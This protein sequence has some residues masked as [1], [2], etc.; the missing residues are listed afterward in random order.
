MRF[1]FALVPVFFI[2]FSAACAAAEIE[3][4]SMVQSAK[5]KVVVEGSGE[6]TGSLFGRSAEIE[7]LSFQDGTG[8]KVLSLEERL[9]INGKTILGEKKL[10]SF[11]NR[12][13]LFKVNETGQFSYRIEAV[14]ETGSA[15]P[16]MQ[17]FDLSQKISRFQNFLLPSKNIESNSETIRTIALNSFESSSFLQTIVDVTQWVHDSV[18]YDL[19][20][21]PENYSAL[22]TLQSRKGVCDEYSVLAAA[23]LRAKGIP[24]KIIAG[25]SYNPLAE[26]G[27]DNHAWVESFNPN[28][29]WTAADPTFAEAGV[30]DGT[31]IARGFF[32][33]PSEASISKSMAPQTA[34]VSIEEKTIAIELQESRE[35]ENLFS[36]EAENIALNTQQWFEFG[37]KA[38]NE[39][40]SN[41]IGWFTLA[42]P[43]GFK[44][45]GETRLLLFQPREEKE[46]IWSIFFENAL[47][48]NQYI[49]GTYKILYLG[50]E[51]EKNLKI[52]PNEAGTEEAKI[53]LLGIVPI[54]DANRLA[55][56]IT[57]ENTGREKAIVEIVVG[58]FNETVEIPGLETKKII[59]TIPAEEGQSY[60]V[61]INGPG[62][63]FK[64]S[65]TVHAG[66]AIASQPSGNQTA[67]QGK[68]MLEEIGKSLFTAE[69][70]IIAGIIIGIGIIGFLLKELLSK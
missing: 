54:F 41:V 46:I 6:I 21:Y 42:L 30:V 15:S 65:I 20:Y 7:I 5:A 61:S 49:T 57:I 14:V 44:K 60:N 58:D 28:G 37:I 4:P 38:K 36:M 23:M 1:S 31:H 34:D 35:F 19:S 22:S 59:A 9:E 40:E 32:T 8:Q 62:I 39:K 45:A 48:K 18:E 47:Q 53:R 69:A 33:D 2:L 10:D 16:E 66:I 70:A 17:D 55:I 3:N 24:T 51:T 26:K 13:A 50:G 64:T 67:G 63:S 25:M 27:W 56:E 11:G 12:Y 52:M 29:G 68:E 43:Q